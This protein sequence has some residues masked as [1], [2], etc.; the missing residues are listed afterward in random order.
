[1]VVHV[2]Q[3]LDHRSFLALNLLPNYTRFQ[4]PR[5]HTRKL[6]PKPSATSNRGAVSLAMP[7]CE[8]KVQT[9]CPTAPPSRLGKPM[10]R[11]SGRFAPRTD[12]ARPSPALSPAHGRHRPFLENDLDLGSLRLDDNPL[13]AS[14]NPRVE[15]V[16]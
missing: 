6:A 12:H 5:R 8:R 10:E 4:A 1:G 11:I 13:A 2:L 7:R 16:G 15:G 9:A 14:G 3:V